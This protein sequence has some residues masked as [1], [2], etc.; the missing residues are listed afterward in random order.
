VLFYLGGYLFTV[1]AAFMVVTVVLRET[2]AETM[3]SLNGL[4]ARSPLLAAGLALS[5]VSLAG[6][7]LTVGFFGKFLLFKA[8]LA[9]AAETPLL[10]VAV[11]VAIVGV[12]IS[13][14]YYFGVIR[15][16]YWGKA[17]WTDAVEP[18]MTA[19]L[20]LGASMAGV[21]ILGVFPSGLWEAARVAVATLVGP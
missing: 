10:Y 9:A 5:M 21:V 13:F 17:E 6:I 3:E 8:A 4:H 1:L 7:P 12:V 15:A 11:A 20:T 19:R 16:V 2:G 14:Y 18:S